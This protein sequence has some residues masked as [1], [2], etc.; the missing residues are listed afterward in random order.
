MSAKKRDPFS[1]GLAGGK[2]R[3]GIV[4]ESNQAGRVQTGV[5]TVVYSARVPEALGRT[6]TVLSGE[7]GRSKQELTE[8]A[9]RDL[10]AKYGRDLLP[11]LDK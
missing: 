1:A 3:R 4:G 7:L 10:L 9:L 2:A 11:P 5:Q 6:M 8:E